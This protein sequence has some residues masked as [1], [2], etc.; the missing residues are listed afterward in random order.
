LSGY[1]AHGAP[2]YYGPNV[3][4]NSALTKPC[5]LKCTWVEGYPP[6]DLVIDLDD[7]AMK[8]GAS[9]YTVINITEEYVTRIKDADTDLPISGELMILNRFNGDYKRAWI[10]MFCKNGPPNCGGTVLRAFTQS[11]K[12][13]RPMF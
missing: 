5:T 4:I 7:R 6:V 2:W 12:C 11:G 13:L 1:A 3:A 8:L 10:G 9:R